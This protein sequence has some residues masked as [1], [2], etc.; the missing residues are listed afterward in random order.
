M[1][2]T[3]PS[4]CDLVL[5]R[6]ADAVQGWLA[7]LGSPRFVAVD[8]ETSGWDPWTDAL[9]TVQVCAGPDRPV[10]VVDAD[11][12]DARVLAPLLASDDVLKVFHHGAFDLRF[13]WRAGIAVSRVA[14]T[15]LAQR[16]LE[17][18]ASGGPGS[19]LASIARFRLGV[20]LDK[21][22]RDT[23]AGGGALTAAQVQYGA[24]DAAATWGVFDQQWRELL[25]HG[26][27]RVARIEFDAMP[28][29]AALQ[30]RGAG[31]DPVAWRALVAEVEARLPELES[32]VQRA[33]VTESSP[34][35]LFG[36][37][38][39][40]LESP[41]QVKA[42]LDRL[43]I[44]VDTTRESVLSRY[45]AHPAV[46]ALLQYR[47]VSRVA[48]S[49][50]GDWADRVAHIAT[51]RVHADWRQI[52]GT[53]RM[54]CSDPNLTQVPKDARYRACF[55]AGEAR[56]LVIADYSQ[57]EL[58]I[59]AAVSGDQVM[60]SLFREGADLHRSTAAMVFG[61]ALDGVSHEQRAAAK[62]LNFGLMYG[63]GAPAFA[64]STKTDLATA[65][66]T[67][68][69]YF[70]AFPAVAAWLRDV[71]VTAK[72]T[73]RVRTP[74]GRIRVLDA[75]EAGSVTLAR[76]APIQG[77][78]ADMTKRALG[79]VAQRLDAR[80]GASPGEPVGPTLVVH[81]ELVVE[82]PAADAAEAAA[83]VEDAMLEAAV[84]VLG[85][86]PA[87]VDVDVRSAW[88]AVPAAVPT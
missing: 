77:A 36:A 35:N 72:R 80:F 62:A 82:V 15:M 39:V 11:A 18:G 75:A 83:L 61:V 84:E 69:R 1:A 88:G 86:V 57:Q 5:A 78:G 54:A 10:L 68:D 6:D 13:L 23:F 34:Q 4:A 26:L 41:E 71:E 40:N 52:V 38:P 73:G 27:V 20:E 16:L 79:L 43:G 63:M 24:E 32:A 64:R 50:G 76:N 47:E 22:V 2:D 7:A 48:Q 59:L 51:G 70:G 74:L 37:E 67:I 31:F 65:K 85:E 3:W 53:G 46:A 19:G 87:R 21:S 9:R 56:S 66:A 14:D 29:L 81:D 30:H 45:A 25:G 60:A 55:P 33:L 28:A 42:A 49:W 12:V 58:R 8:C 17:G 44:G